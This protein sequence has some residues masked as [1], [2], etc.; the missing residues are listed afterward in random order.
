VRT[1]LHIPEDAPAWEQCWDNNKFTYNLNDSASEWIYPIM[2]DAGIRMVFYSGD[3]DGAV[4]TWG[5]KRLRL[6]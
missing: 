2:K 1:A 5:T 4:P 6:K 3:T